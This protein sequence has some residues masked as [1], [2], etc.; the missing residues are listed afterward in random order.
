M[1]KITFIAIAAFFTL[2]LASC[3][4]DWTCKCTVTTN[5]VTTTAESTISATKSDA[6]D[7]CAE[8]NVSASAG[9]ISSSASCELSKK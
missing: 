6:E 8:G 4:R 2:S 1:K 7:E 5:G 3:K 9:G